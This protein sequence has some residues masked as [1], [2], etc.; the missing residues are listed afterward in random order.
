MR[1]Q[2]RWCSKKCRQLLWRENFL[3]SAT[4]LKFAETS[5]FFVSANIK[6]G[7]IKQANFSMPPKPPP[8]RWTK[9]EK[10]KLIELVQK[11]GNDWKEISSTNLFLFI[12]INR[13]F[14]AWFR[15]SKIAVDQVK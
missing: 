12:L 9:E 10:L 7:S 2:V 4:S 3:G 13:T 5:L 14:K 8:R 15:L 1:I 11:F 6:E